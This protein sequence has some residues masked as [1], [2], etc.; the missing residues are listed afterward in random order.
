MCNY[1]VYIVCRKHT[2]GRVAFHRDWLL[3]LVVAP[4]FVS[5]ERVW[6]RACLGQ[7]QSL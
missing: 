3:G 5:P 4:A 2:T 7:L 1:I 6:A